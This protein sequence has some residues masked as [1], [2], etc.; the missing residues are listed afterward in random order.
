MT[1]TNLT[2]ARRRRFRKIHFEDRHLEGVGSFAV[3]FILEDDAD[4]L[5]AYVHFYGVLLLRPLDDRDR[6]QA[7]EVPKILLEAP[8][9]ATCQRIVLHRPR[10]NSHEDGVASSVTLA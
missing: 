6:I 2:G 8:D 10:V 9:L 1:E 7:E 4:K 3:L 5:T